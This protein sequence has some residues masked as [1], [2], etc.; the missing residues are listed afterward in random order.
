M[1]LPR[2]PVGRVRDQPTHV[3]VPRAVPELRE[4]ATE[5]VPVAHELFQPMKVDSLVI[6]FF[7]ELTL[8]SQSGRADLDELAR[9]VRQRDPSDAC[10]E[11]LT[12]SSR[13]RSRGVPPTSRNGRGPRRRPTNHARTRIPLSSAGSASII[14]GG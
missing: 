8:A 4:A 1:A 13:C 9:E 11:S 2:K 5:R 3:A 12:M 14:S 10:V 6:A 7:V